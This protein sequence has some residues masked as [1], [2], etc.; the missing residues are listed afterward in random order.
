MNEDLP[1]VNLTQEEVN[2]LRNKKFELTQYGKQKLRKMMNDNP[3]IDE[4]FDQGKSS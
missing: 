1:W 2:D 4:M 3:T